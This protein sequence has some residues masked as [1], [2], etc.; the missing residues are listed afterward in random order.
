MFPHRLLVLFG[1]AIVQAVWPSKMP[2]ANA[3]AIL[4]FLD[5]PVGIDPAFH[6][7]WATFRMMRSILHFVLRWNLAPFVCLI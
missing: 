6:L 5:G 7:V 2:L 3:P 1:P 4:N